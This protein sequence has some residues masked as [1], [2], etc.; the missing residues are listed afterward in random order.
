M[1]NPMSTTAIDILLYLFGA[2]AA[3]EEACAAHSDDL[4]GLH[5]HVACLDAHAAYH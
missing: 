4:A 3:E 2:T 1:A 5:C